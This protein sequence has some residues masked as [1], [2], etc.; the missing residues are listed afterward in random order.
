VTKKSKIPKSLQRTFDQRFEAMQ[1]PQ[2]KAAA[3]ALFQATPEELGRAA[4]MGAKRAQNEATKADHQAGGT[5]GVEGLD[6]AVS[7][8]KKTRKNKTPKPGYPG[9]PEF[10]QVVLEQEAGQTVL[11]CKHRRTLGL[12]RLSPEDRQAEE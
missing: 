3:K 2:S 9:S 1:T 8:V 7:K 4:V 6:Q 12:E 11:A 5:T 10:I